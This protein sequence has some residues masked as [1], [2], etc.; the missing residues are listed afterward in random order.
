L[1]RS[2]VLENGGE[3]PWSRPYWLYFNDQTLGRDRCRIR[4]D[5]PIAAV[6]YQTATGIT[7]LSDARASGAE[8]GQELT[9]GIKNLDST[10]AGIENKDVPEPV[11]RHALGVY[12]LT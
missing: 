7:Q 11:D 3:R 1:L 2:I 9:P 4:N 5:D 10:I 12:E 6:Q 8:S